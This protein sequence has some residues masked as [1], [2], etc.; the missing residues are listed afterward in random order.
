M[1][2]SPL[3]NIIPMPKQTKAKTKA[4]TQTNVK[5]KVQPKTPGLTTKKWYWAMLAGVM[6]AVFSVA[7]HMMEFSLPQIAILI[8]TILFLFGLM[9]Y[10]GTTSSNLSKSKRATFLFVGASVIGFGIWAIIMLTLTSMNLSEKV[11]PDIF[12]VVLS[13]V[14]VLIAGAFTGELLGKNKRV[15]TFFFKPENTP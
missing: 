15:Q 1:L 6:A 7:G 8:L 10:V 2:I 12:F 3:T 9:G 14:I 5:R 13:F 11:F 4:K